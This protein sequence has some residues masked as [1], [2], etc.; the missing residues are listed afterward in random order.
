MHAPDPNLHGHQYE[1]PV[2][3]PSEAGIA[4]LLVTLPIVH[5]ALRSPGEPL[6]SATMAFFGP[7]F[8]HDFTGVRVHT[9]GIA[10]AAAN[11]LNA[12]A[13]TVGN[14]IVFGTGRYSPASNAGNQLLAHELT[15]VMQQAGRPGSNVLQRAPNKQEDPKQQHQQWLEE[16]AKWPESAHK[17]WKTLNSSDRSLVVLQIASIYGTLFA[18]E[19]LKVAGQPKSADMIAEYFGPAVG[20]KPGGL[21]A[22]GF[23]LAMKDSVHEWWV[24]PSGKEITRNFTESKPGSTTVRPKAPEGVTPVP[25]IEGTNGWPTQ[26]DPNTDRDRLFGPVVAVRNNVDMSFGSGD[27]LRYADGT[28][29]LFLEATTKSYVFRPLP[30]GRYVVYDPDGKSLKQFWVLPKEEIPEPGKDDPD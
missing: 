30:D 22:R 3:N 7:R 27:V 18:N 1:R 20:P 2:V 12:T 10:A 29:E 16:L 17:A 6:D 11:A 15:H 25:V 13:F 28:V 19:F 26:L 9:D 5:E 24:H 8:M 23:R 14:A 4:D 21:I